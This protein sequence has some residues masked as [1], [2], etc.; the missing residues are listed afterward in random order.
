MGP[1]DV[2]E[3]LDSVGAYR[4]VRLKESVDGLKLGLVEI[5]LPVVAVLRLENVE[6]GVFVS[7]RLSGRA[8]LTCARCLKPF[9]D[10]F[11]VDVGDMFSSDP[12]DD[13]YEISDLGSIDP[14]PMV[15]DAVLLA[16]PF[17]P[18][19]RED[20]RGLCPRCGGDRNLK[21][22]ECPEQAADP[23]WAVLEKLVDNSSN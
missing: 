13:D 2:S 10:D 23:R 15:R 11:G 20:C 16:M 17:S 9:E 12:G 22:C 14:E 1:I 4:D 18:L 5:V 8:E 21:E 6:D 19:C 3:L 7:G